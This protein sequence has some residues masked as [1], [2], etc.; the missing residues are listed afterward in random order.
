MHSGP[1]DY[2]ANAHYYYENIINTLILFTKKKE[3]L[4]KLAGP[5]FDPLFEL[6]SELDYAFLPVLF[7]TVFRK[8]L[9][10]KELQTSLLDFK[11]YV[12]DIDSS[13]WDYEFIDHH[14]KWIA[15][16]ANADDLLN[17]LGI[18]YRN[19]SDDSTIHKI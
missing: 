18:N 1:I 15:A 14:P 10:E 9:I 16:R 4:L 19:Y 17:E 7:E 13:I 8:N 5:V 6:E 3:D 12:D 2:D 11:K